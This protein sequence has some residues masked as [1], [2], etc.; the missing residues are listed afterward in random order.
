MIEEGSLVKLVGMEH[1][2]STNS[3]K[4]WLNGLVGNVIKYRKSVNVH[5]GHITESCNIVLLVPISD[6]KNN[7]IS[8]LFAINVKNLEEIERVPIKR[9]PI[10]SGNGGKQ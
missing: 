2:F 7:Q 4:P 9:I 3:C 6:S 5:D 10:I 8:W 1:D